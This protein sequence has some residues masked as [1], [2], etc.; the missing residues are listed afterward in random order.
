[1]PIPKP[2]PHERMSEFITRCMVDDTMQEEYP[3]ERQRVAVCA[4][5]WSSK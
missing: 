2:E 1:M 4:K 3:N 5:Q